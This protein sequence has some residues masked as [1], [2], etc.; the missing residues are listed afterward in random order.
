MTTRTKLTP[1]E[2]AARR[3]EKKRAEL[4]RRNLAAVGGPNSLFRDEAVTVTTEQAAWHLRREQAVGREQALGGTGSALDVQLDL[5]RLAMVE[6]FAVAAVGETGFT[7]LRDYC[8]RVYPSVGYWLG[9][10]RRCLTAGDQVVFEYLR[11]EGPPFKPGFVKLLPAE[12]WPADGWVP[13]LTTAEFDERFPVWDSK[14]ATGPGWD[15]GGALFDDV[16]NRIRGGCR[17]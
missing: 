5:L 3:T 7:R 12:S 16:M 10:W 1:A 9:F 4:E 11:L 13:P 6:R 8:R 17:R 14:P 15:S 2:I